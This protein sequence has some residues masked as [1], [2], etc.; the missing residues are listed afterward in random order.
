MTQFNDLVQ[1]N[2]LPST[3]GGND[4]EVV[5]LK[6]QLATAVKERDSANTQRDL[7]MTQFNDLVQ[8]NTLPSTRGMAEPSASENKSVA[9]NHD[10]SADGLDELKVVFDSMK[11]DEDGN[12]SYKIWMRSLNKNQVVL[13]KFLGGENAADLGKTFKKLAHG[14]NSLSWADFVAGARQHANGISAWHSNRAPDPEAPN[15]TSLV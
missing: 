15:W 7:L 8:E 10:A 9:H 5:A 1:E 11:K 4:Q 3:R 14:T 13:S 2:T 6:T 12:V